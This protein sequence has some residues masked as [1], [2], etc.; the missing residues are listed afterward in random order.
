MRNET[1]AGDAVT[2][3][4]GGGG[5]SRGAAQGPGGRRRYS[6]YPS[7][8][9]AFDAW[10]RRL[11][12]LSFSPVEVLRRAWTLKTHRIRALPVVIL[13]PHSRC[14]CRCVMCDI[15]K[16][17]HEGNEL[18]REDL[19]PHL[20]ALVR[21]RARRVILSGGEALMHSNLWTLC[22]LLRRKAKLRIT[23]LSSGLLLERHAVDI[24]RW[25]DHVV[26]SLDGS[27]RV[28]DAIR[29][30]PRAYERLAA[31]VESLKRQA[32]GL[33]VTGRSVLQRRNYFDLHNIVASARALGLDQISFLAADTTSQAFN[34]PQPWDETRACEVAL[35][36]SQ[37]AELRD[38]VERLVVDCA[39]DFAAGFI[40]ES[41]QRLRR[42]AEDLAVATEGG[43][44]A[45]RRCNAPW[46]STVVEADGTVRPC[47]F[48]PAVGNLL[49]G[50]L[51]EILN[52][53]RALEFR[54]R[55]DVGSD[56]IC[57][58]CVCSLELAPWIQVVDP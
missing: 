41:P 29:N 19:E 49:E 44:G 52:S 37:A 56:P 24:G 51:E 38:L 35:D 48:Q 11:R 9:P 26:V 3:S 23:L 16:S 7:A 28:H 34:R 39:A 8:V 15:W 22:E 27:P 18:R 14:N 17:N 40:A 58:R 1:P 46:V 32:P 25:C 43:V 36:A 57:R 21:L 45:P 33:R 5:A 50:P 10:S 42:L 4:A 20:K 54:R 13:M 30:V 31:G 53:Q 6:R 55:L 2:G 12:S 47:F